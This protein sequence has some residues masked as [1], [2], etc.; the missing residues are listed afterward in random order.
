MQDQEAG[1]GRLV[2]RGVERELG[3]G[4]LWGET[5]KRDNVSKENTQFKNTVV[6]VHMRAHARTHTHTHTH[7]HT[8]VNNAS[9]KQVS[10]LTCLD[11]S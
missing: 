3:E 10:D 4:F 9:Q 7:T 2:R 11:F 1:V 6:H 8:Q 5:R